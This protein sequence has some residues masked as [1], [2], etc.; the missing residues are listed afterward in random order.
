M[1]L[2]KVWMRCCLDT[3]ILYF[4]NP[5]KRI[6][7]VFHRD[8]GIQLLLAFRMWSETLS[9]QML[10]ANGHFRLKEVKSVYYLINQ[11]TSTFWYS[12][13]SRHNI[14]KHELWRHFFSKEVLTTLNLITLNKGPHFLFPNIISFLLV[15]SLCVDCRTL[16]ILIC[17]IVIELIILS[18]ISRAWSRKYY[19]QPCFICSLQDVEETDPPV[20]ASYDG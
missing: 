5:I 7:K 17:Y 4:P 2:F 10:M 9:Y 16:V 1:F 14:T 8:V 18:S 12:S 13:D 11:S 19:G 15:H 3:S 6:R 20:R